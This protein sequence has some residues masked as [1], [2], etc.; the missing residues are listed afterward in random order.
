MNA[1]VTYETLF[2]KLN[3]DY[4]P[5]FK[6][7]WS[8]FMSILNRSITNEFMKN[9]IANILSQKEEKLELNG[10]VFLED[11][12]NDDSIKLEDRLPSYLKYIIE[13]I[14]KNSNTVTFNLYAY[15]CKILQMY[16]YFL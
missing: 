15:F 9:N 10:D 7:N 5:E 6:K 2:K 16:I 13:N 3:E 11:L 12:K 4:Y 14:D 1:S 8:N